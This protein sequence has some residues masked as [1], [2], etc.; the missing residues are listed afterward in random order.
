MVG[1]TKSS[2]S[3]DDKVEE[4]LKQQGEKSSGT[5]EN[6]TLPDPKPNEEPKKEETPE[7]ELKKEPKEQ[8]KE[9]P[10][11]DDGGEEKKDDGGDSAEEP[12]GAK[13]FDIGDFNE[14]FKTEFKDAETLESSLKRV[15]ELKQF[16]T[17]TKEKQDL[18]TKIS[19]LQTKYDEAVKLTDPRQHF[20]NEE[21]YKRQVILKEH[22]ADIN[23]ALLHKI[24]GVDVNKLSD[25]DAIVMWKQLSNPNLRGGEVGA[26]NLVVRQ[27]G[28][29]ADMSPDDWD[30]DVRNL[31]SD[32]SVPARKQ[33]QEIKDVDVP[34]VKNFEEEAK[35]RAQAE[36]EKRAALTDTW[37][38]ISD[39]VLEDF[40][41]YDLK[42]DNEEG[43]EE[44]F[45]S[46][47]VGNDFKKD[48]KELMVDFL[49]DRGM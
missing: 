17:V 45:F 41:T 1:E 26:R 31:I 25:L 35:A 34:E 16:D 13:E 39:K 46:Y 43:V 40:S 9:E 24:I 21:E 28:I 32:A 15:S 12:E 7:E 44:T 33:L 49:V 38:K 5:Q 37:D 20:A 23:P 8:P 10:R 27:L 6:D 36:K 19:E 3:F 42:K 29:D 30:D 4:A 2:E 48:A 11:E 14:R 18:E 47:E 22:K